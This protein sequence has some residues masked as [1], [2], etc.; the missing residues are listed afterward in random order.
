MVKK[1]MRKIILYTMMFIV[2]IIA[3]QKSN[4]NQHVNT[5]FAFSQPKREQVIQKEHKAR[6]VKVPSEGY[7][8][9]TKNVLIKIEAQSPEAREAFQD[10]IVQWNKTEVINFQETNDQNDAQ[11]I[12]NEK[13]L[14]SGDS[15]DGIIQT[16]QLGVTDNEYDPS[17]MILQKSTSSLDI[18]ELRSYSRK[19]RMWVAEHELGHAIGLDHARQDS[20]SVMV[21]ENP[22][23]G[24]TVNDINAVKR[25]YG[26]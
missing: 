3:I 4:M 13:N 5:S 11:I 21:P 17:T 6:Q 15:N 26:N 18:Q 1:K 20:D 24:I 10:A 9:P 19:Y 14:S 7:R 8:W 23:T 16:E 22:K 25:I 12:A 2:L